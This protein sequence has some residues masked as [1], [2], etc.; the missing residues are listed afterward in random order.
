MVTRSV[1][2]GRPRPAAPL[3]LLASRELTAAMRQ[4]RVAAG[5][6][7]PSAVEMLNQ[8]IRSL[9][10]D[11]APVAAGRAG[12]P[13]PH[14]VDATFLRKVEKGHHAR[15]D[16]Y[17]LPKWI[18]VSKVHDRTRL[19]TSRV[20]QWLVRAYDLAFC[21]N[22]YLVD[23]CAWSSALLPDQ[24]RDVPRRLRGLPAHVPPGAEY[25]FLAEHFRDADE[26][27]R[28]LLSEQAELVAARRERR[29]DRAVPWLPAA[30][31]ESSSRDDIVE[32]RLLPPDG[33]VVA[34]WHLTNSGSVPWRDRVLYRVG[35]YPSGVRTPPFLVI[36]D[37]DPGSTVTIHC[38]MR[39]PT[40]AGTYRACLKAGW[41]D[42]TYCFPSTLLGLFATVI[43]APDDL[44]DPMVEWPDHAG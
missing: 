22:G 20:P 17:R 40:T 15:L 16:L 1:L 36:P 39:A 42:G 2:R 3:H 41:P 34:T 24:L 25:A 37:T 6:E 11:A 7:L 9:Y 5:D 32:G 33:Q 35:A 13:A 10:P 19:Y 21:A 8:A 38:P 23:M 29:P 18:D 12:R 14:L 4:L 44:A 30:D 26:R 27:V 43:V 31:D 28:A